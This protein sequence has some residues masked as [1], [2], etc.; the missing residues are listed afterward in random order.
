MSSDNLIYA[1]MMPVEVMGKMTDMYKEGRTY[2]VMVDD[3]LNP[4]A[5]TFSFGLN[6][7][8][9]EYPTNTKIRL[10]GEEI[11]HL[12]NCIAEEP[13]AE[14]V[15]EGRYRRFVGKRQVCRF[16]ITPTSWDALPERAVLLDVPGAAVYREDTTK[17]PKQDALS[18]ELAEMLQ[19]IPD[20]KDVTVD[21]MMAARENELASLSYN[22]LKELAKE[23][24][25]KYAGV[26]K[27]DLIE[28]I[29]GVE[30]KLLR[31]EE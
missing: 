28:N 7:K 20:G 1:S 9:G 27:V 6:G 18:G 19:E 11:Q 21:E 15:G 4:G 8:I 5:R 14:E 12:Y 30:E 3:R 22:D 10:L 23:R 16:S 31:G 2:E 13:I 24:D 29:L 17:A 25:I 26:S